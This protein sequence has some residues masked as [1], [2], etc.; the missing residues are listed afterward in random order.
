MARNHYL[1]GS[2]QVGSREPRPFIQNNKYRTWDPFP[3]SESKRRPQGSR[4]RG[5]HPAAYWAPDAYPPHVVVTR[6]RLHRKRALTPLPRRACFT[7]DGTAGRGRRHT[8]AQSANGAYRGGGEFGRET[9]GVSMS[10]RREFGGTGPHAE[11]RLHVGDHGR[12][13]DRAAVGAG[14]AG[15]QELM[16]IHAFYSI[17]RSIAARSRY[18]TKTR[19][20]ATRTRSRRPQIR[21]EGMPDG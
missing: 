14:D 10:V 3:L 6:V 15:R 1:I 9:E 5:T 21:S 20:W 18:P 16:L 13:R 19:S 11:R 2:V 17:E 4:V 12:D 7:A 8:A